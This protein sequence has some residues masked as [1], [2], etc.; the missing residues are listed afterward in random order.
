MHRIHTPGGSLPLYRVTSTRAIEHQALAGV[1]PHA[2]MQRAGS[3]VARLALAL[4][5][6][7]RRVWLAAG[8][9]NN[10]GDGLVAAMQMC[11][12]GNDVI[13]TLLGDAQ[14]LPDDAHAARTR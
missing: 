5:P 1:A 10:G 11:A 8:P 14:R 4:A 9:G 6:H 2:L 13:V 7:A 12:A 3:A